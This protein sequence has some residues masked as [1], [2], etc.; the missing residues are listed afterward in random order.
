MY[1]TADDI[2]TDIEGS[3]TGSAADDTDQYI[4]QISVWAPTVQGTGSA[5]TYNVS[6]HKW[7]G[8]NFTLNPGDGS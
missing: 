3:L 1:A 2:V 6:K 7:A 8:T 4:K 5:V